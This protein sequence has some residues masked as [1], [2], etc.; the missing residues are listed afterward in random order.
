MSSTMYV[1]IVYVFYLVEARVKFLKIRLRLN[2]AHNPYINT[3]TGSS[4][5]IPAPTVKQSN[6]IDY[7]QNMQI[8]FRGFS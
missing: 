8:Y 5:N 3:Y 7:S 4:Q 1:R 2:L 6:K